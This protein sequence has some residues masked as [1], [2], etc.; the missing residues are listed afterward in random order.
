MS[1]LLNDLVDYSQ[2]E[3]GNISLE[4]SYFN[5]KNEISYLIKAFEIQ[6]KLSKNQFSFSKNIYL[7]CNKQLL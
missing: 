6:S 5:I 1:R 3:V 2:M 7:T 4:K